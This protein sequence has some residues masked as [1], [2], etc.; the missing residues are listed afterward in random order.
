MLRGLGDLAKMGGLLQQALDMRKR[1]EEMKAELAEQR[2]EGETLGGAVRVVV[3]GA[4]EIES[5]VISRDLVSPERSE[6]LA[7]MVQAAV[8]S[9]IKTAQEYVQQRMRDLTGGYDIPGIS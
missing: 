8:N 1:I 9:A 6:E 5:L 2:F 7:A 3:N 4:L